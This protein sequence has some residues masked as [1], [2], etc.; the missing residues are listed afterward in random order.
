[1]GK[2]RPVVSS[3]GLPIEYLDLVVNPRLLFL[4]FTYLEA[5]DQIIQR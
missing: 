2:S 4:M 1:M 5:Y 3:V